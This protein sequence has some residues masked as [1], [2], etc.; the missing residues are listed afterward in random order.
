MSVLRK[1]QSNITVL[2][3]V[4]D[5]PGGSS[6]TS[7]TLGAEAT[8]G[9]D[10]WTWVP[11]PDDREPGDLLLPVKADLAPPN[12]IPE[13]PEKER[14]AE[15]LALPLQSETEGIPPVFQSRGMPSLPPLQSLLLVQKEKVR[16]QELQSESSV[17]VPEL[18]TDTVS[19]VKQGMQTAGKETSGV[20]QDGTRWWQ[21]KG[22]EFRANGVICNWTVIRGVS[23]D[24]SVEWEEKFWE[25]ADAYDFKEL[26]AEKSGRDSLGGVWR[27]FWQESMWQVRLC[28]PSSHARVSRWKGELIAELFKVS[29]FH[30]QKIIMIF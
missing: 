7:L 2:C 11:P 27:E 16:K 12:M 22:T 1:K 13:L 25:A 6:A 14:Q 15:T 8:P 24:G 4:G 29:L 5:F 10:F 9:P 17:P 28:S 3:F 19:G 18:E 30:L 21:E 23:A 20:H 26:G